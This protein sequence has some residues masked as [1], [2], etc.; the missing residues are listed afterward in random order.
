[1]SRF[2]ATFA[3]RHVVLPIINVNSLDQ[4]LTNVRIAREAG[5]DGC[6]LISLGLASDDELLDIHAA[7]RAREPAFWLGINCVG[8]TLDR[9]FNR[10]DPQVSGVWAD[11]ALI[12]E[13]T[14]DQPAALRVQQLQ[15]AR[16]WQGLY[17]G[18]VA[19]KYQRPVRDVAAAAR[20][21]SRYM[22]L[23]TTS[24]PG[25]G[26]P[27]APE[28]VRRMK[29]AI[30]TTP[31]ALASGVTPENVTDYLASADCFL[32]S[33]GISSTLEDLDPDRIR[34]LLQVIRTW[35]DKHP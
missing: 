19:F 22:D 15:Q 25:T 3:H 8:L 29:Q 24:G 12:D 27:A 20:K 7:V 5:A 32:V 4:A 35:E 17:F 9:L 2:R 1:M 26:L 34:D 10:L 33:T 6:F 23:V 16:G 18:G 11:D 30:G 28:K 21:A 14:T 13:T 31:L